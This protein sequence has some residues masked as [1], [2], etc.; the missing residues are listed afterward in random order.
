MIRKLMMAAGLAALAAAGPALA[1]NEERAEKP[2]KEKKICR[3]DKVTGSLARKR[4][5]CMTQKEWDE[6]AARTKQSLD[7]YT[8]NAGGAPKCISLTCDS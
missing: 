4:R 3:T 1:D 8:G 5:T 7:E 2:A 6:L